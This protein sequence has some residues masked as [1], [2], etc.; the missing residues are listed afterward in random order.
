MMAGM[1]EATARR[2]RGW[3]RVVGLPVAV[4]G[5]VALLAAPAAG[6]P[7]WQPPQLIAPPTA[8]NSTIAQSA[9]GDALVV[10]FQGSGLGSRTLYS[11]RAPARGVERPG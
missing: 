3:A 9:R 2:C 6:A 10:W 11:W 8:G 7:R 1:V 5:G 4:V